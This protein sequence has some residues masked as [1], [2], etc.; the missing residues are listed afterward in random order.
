MA[1]MYPNQVQWEP[2]RDAERKIYEACE[3]QLDNSYTVFYSVAW[4]ALNAEG[5]PRDGEADFLIAHPERGVLVLEVKGGAIHHDPLTGS[6]ASI[7]R[8]GREHSIK[9]SYAQARDGKYALRDWF[10]GTQGRRDIRMNIGHAV[11]FPDT[12]PGDAPPGPDRPRE[13]TLY[14]V[15]LSEFSRWAGACLTH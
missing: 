13:I 5:R 6:W 11:A 14:S 9:D 3:G 1:R 15:D 4:H 10:A 8:G 7:D 2:G 12:V